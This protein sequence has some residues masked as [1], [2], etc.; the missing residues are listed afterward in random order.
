MV[1]YTTGLS[2][3]SGKLAERKILFIKKTM[4]RLLSQIIGEEHIQIINYDV[5]WKGE[6]KAL[7]STHMLSFHGLP[8]DIEFKEGLLLSDLISHDSSYIIM[9]FAGSEIRDK[10][11]LNDLHFIDTSLYYDNDQED[12]FLQYLKLND[13]HE[14]PGIYHFAYG[15]TTKMQLTDRSVSSVTREAGQI[16]VEPNPEA[17]SLASFFRK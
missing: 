17:S 13:R 12:A 5:D 16:V 2:D 8:I 11:L 4:D 10:A 14:M 6:T 9:N 15:S 1:I 7:L 3:D